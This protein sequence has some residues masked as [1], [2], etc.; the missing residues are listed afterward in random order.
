MSEHTLPILDLRDFT[1][2]TKNQRDQFVLRLRETAHDIGFFYLRGLNINT[3]AKNQLFSLSRQFFNL[4]FK[5]KVAL[6]MSNSPHFRGYTREGEELTRGAYDWREQLDVGAERE[7]LPCLPHDPAWK[8]LQG[9]NQWPAQLPGLKPALLQLQET[10]TQASLHVLRALSLALGQDETAFVQAFAD[11]PVQHMK[12]IRYPG[13]LSSHSQQ[14]VGA[15]KDSGCLT[16]VLQHQQ[17][18]LQVHHQGAW[19]DVHPIEDTVV[20][21]LG[22][23]LEILTNGY[24]RATLHRVQSPA[25]GQ[26]RLSIAFFLSPRLEASLPPLVLPPELASVA[27]GVELDPVNPLLP[28]TGQNLL[29]GRLRSHPEVAR[30]FYADVTV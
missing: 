19:V 10:F 4:S 20:V 3:T 14:G 26:D 29:K 17:Q 25:L 11:T 24:L 18:G 13:R 7:V 9:P 21:N 16:F 5:E 15:H 23:V 27:R 22:E 6:D 30:R 8:R 2:G 1:E 28:H 12:V